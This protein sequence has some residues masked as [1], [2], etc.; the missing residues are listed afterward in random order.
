M[1]ELIG[2][3]V[4]GKGAEQAAA[5]MA[6][7]IR[8]RFPC[9]Q[10]LYEQFLCKE[11]DRAHRAHTAIDEEPIGTGITCAGTAVGSSGVLTESVQADSAPTGPPIT[12]VYAREKFSHHAV[13]EITGA[14]PGFAVF[15]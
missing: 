15:D 11:E 1:R 8:Q 7:G 4:A 6:V 14:I 2:Y 10:F 13:E 9:K 12:I 3:L 5:P